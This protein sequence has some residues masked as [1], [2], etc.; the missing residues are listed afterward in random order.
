MFNQGYPTT[1]VKKESVN[2]REHLESRIYT[3]RISNRTRFRVEID[4]YSLNIFIVKFCL[5]NST[6]KNKYSVLANVGVTE[7]SRII[8][9]SLD[10][11]L[12]IARTEAPNASFGFIGSEK[13]QEDKHNTTRFRIYKLL[14]ISSFS[15]DN[16]LHVD[17]IDRSAYLIV[18][19]NNSNPEKIARRAAKFFARI[20]EWE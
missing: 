7:A 16:Y 8:R 14:C 9:T 4:R 5:A 13:E 1:L 11:C 15:K 19:K 12:N 17:D 3:F 2:D 6:A 20:Y 18:S 10:V